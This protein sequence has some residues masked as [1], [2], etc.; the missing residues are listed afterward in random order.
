MEPGAAAKTLLIPGRRR[1]FG[2][3]VFSGG[4]YRLSLGSRIPKGLG[5]QPKDPWPGDGGKADALFRG[6]F[7]FAGDHSYLANKEPWFAEDMSEHWHRNLHGFDWIRDFADNASDAGCRHAVALTTSW[8]KHFSRPVPVLWDRECLQT[9]VSNWLCHSD[10]LIGTKEDSFRD[11]FLQSLKQQCRHLFRL[12]KI[13]GADIK[14]DLTLLTTLIYASL[15]FKKFKTRLEPLVRQLS[16]T[17]PR[18]IL[19]D[20]CH[21]SRNP[22]EHLKILASLTGLQENLGRAGLSVP[23]SLTRALDRL[24]PMIAFSSMAMA[25]SVCSM[26]DMSQPATYVG[27]SS[28]SPPAAKYRLSAARPAGLRS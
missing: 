9:R 16:M 1:H 11:A 22:E 18:V 25:A 4:L 26:A 19:K 24:T 10:F 23:P 28:P 17:L 6:S 3:I 12:Y 15:C 20:G 14:A 2:D 7:D 13:G 27:I 8:L 5:F 21:I